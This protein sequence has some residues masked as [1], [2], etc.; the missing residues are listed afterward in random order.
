MSCTD[1]TCHGRES[2]IRTFGGGRL[3]GARAG[4]HGVRASS[5]HAYP[6]LSIPRSLP[7]R[8]AVNTEHRRYRF[9]AAS[10]SLRLAY[11]WVAV[12]GLVVALASVA[13]PTALV[14]RGF[15][16]NPATASAG[17]P[18]DVHGPRGVGA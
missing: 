16:N 6:W 12:V 9:G 13:A 7:W 4:R 5:Q 1:A 17:R 10:A 8:T 14:A 15:D 18:G 3:E 2:A 11:V